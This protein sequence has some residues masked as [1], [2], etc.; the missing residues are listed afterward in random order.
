MNIMLLYSNGMGSDD[1]KAKK[2][3][4][5]PISVNRTSTNGNHGYL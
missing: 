2:M 1:I 3:K 5:T 4:I